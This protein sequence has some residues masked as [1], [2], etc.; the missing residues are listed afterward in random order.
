MED[1]LWSGAPR[2]YQGMVL[3]CKSVG[4]GTPC[5]GKIA[6]N[7]GDTLVVQ[8]LTAKRENLA[9]IVAQG[10]ILCA[11]RFKP[12]QCTSL[13]ER[14]WIGCSCGEMNGS[15][16]NPAGGFLHLSIYGHLLGNVGS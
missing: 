3:T 16:L 9:I 4:A 10:R 13:A 7:V 5:D 8:C 14:L 6:S 1:G 12:I 2:L 15:V 11:S